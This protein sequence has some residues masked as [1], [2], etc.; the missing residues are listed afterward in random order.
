MR[1]KVARLSDVLHDRR[2]DHPALVPKG[3]GTGFRRLARRIA[4]LPAV[5]TKFDDVIL[6]VAQPRFIVILRDILACT[7]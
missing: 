7:A 2:L 5:Q 3:G 4:T 6:R 1:E